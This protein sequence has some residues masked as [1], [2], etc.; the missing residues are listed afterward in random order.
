MS[1]D[2]IILML[3]VS[4]FLGFFG[5]MAFSW[6]VKSGQFDDEKKFTK[7]LLFDGEEELN[8]A[9]EMEKKEKDSKDKSHLI[10]D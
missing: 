8:E 7:G 9:I 1:S 10:K 6:G 3:G 5:V 2:I 4:I